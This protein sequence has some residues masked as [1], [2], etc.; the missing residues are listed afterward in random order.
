MFDYKLIENSIRS[1]F[2]CYN[3]YT[4]KTDENITL[5]VDKNVYFILQL[6]LE[7]LKNYRKQMHVYKIYS[8]LKKLKQKKV[9]NIFQYLWKKL[10][11][12]DFSN[13][14]PVV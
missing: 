4:W 6:K 5:E 9:E 1:C 11:N 8:R 12:D 10:R 3:I 7:K 2:I 14:D 13:I